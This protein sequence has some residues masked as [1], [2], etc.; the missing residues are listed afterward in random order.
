V[1][2]HS[3]I[4]SIAEPCIH[5]E[6][7]RVRIATAQLHSLLQP[8]RDFY[9]ERFEELFSM[10]CSDQNGQTLTCKVWKGRR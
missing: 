4:L 3:F 9:H 2:F 7:E 8:N 10:I 5:G 6:R 1:V